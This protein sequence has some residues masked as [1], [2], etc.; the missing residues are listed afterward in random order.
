M[1][2]SVVYIER[3]TGGDEDD[4]KLVIIHATTDY[5]KIIT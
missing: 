4:G 1:Y 3:E 2:V 5:N